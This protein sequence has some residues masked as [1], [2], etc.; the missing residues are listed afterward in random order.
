M[1]KYAHRNKHTD[2]LLLLVFHNNAT[3]CVITVG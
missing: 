2:E 1:L 3:Q